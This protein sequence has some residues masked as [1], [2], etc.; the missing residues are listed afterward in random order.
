MY[1]DRV[2]GNAFLVR[3]C[4]EATWTRQKSRRQERVKGKGLP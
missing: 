2:K 3:N 1:K 4:T